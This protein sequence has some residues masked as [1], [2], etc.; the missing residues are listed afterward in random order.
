MKR[1][2]GLRTLIKRW[3]P[4]PSH[5]F[6]LLAVLLL[7]FLGYDYQ[8]S[9]V[10]FTIEFNGVPYP[11]MTH[12]ATVGG[13]L[14]DAGLK[15]EPGDWVRPELTAPLTRG[16]TVEVEPART[17]AIEADGRLIES[18]T[19]ETTPLGVL[20]EAGLA[21]NP[22]DEVLIDARPLA[23]KSSLPLRSTTVPADNPPLP[24]ERPAAQP[25]HLL[26]KRAVALFV[27]NDGIPST[28]YTTATTIGEALLEHDIL[29]YLGDRVTPS[30]GNRVSAGL[31][32]YIQRSK[33]VELV[34]DGHAVRT[35]SRAETVADV[36]AEQYVSLVGKDTVDPP[37][38]TPVR[39]GM[40]IRV[41]RVSRAM[42]VEQDTV[43][44]ET[45]WKPAA[46]LALDQQRVDQQGKEGLT[47]RRIEVLYR[48]GQ[49]VQRE[50]DEEWI[51]AEPQTKIIA[52]GTRITPQTVQTDDG[53]LSYWRKVRMLATSYTAASSGKTRDDPRYGI[54]RSGLPV[55][56]GVVAVDSAVV[57]LGDR[58]YVPGYGIAVVGDTGGGIKGRRIDLGYPEDD[59]VMWY[60]WVDVFVL[61]S[62]PPRDDI[63]WVLPN[64]PREER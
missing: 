28:L 31:K 45:V 17:V 39:D 1:L 13:A 55:E 48:D 63:R 43:A 9:L 30:L 19:H 5:L 47:R 26:V 25:I 46:D 24:W 36:L 41:T 16:M 29:L 38:S 22:F 35:R 51:E 6:L 11:A 61:G 27:D 58:L 52:Y 4:F 12:Q 3:Q 59:P 8:R 18:R 2:A 10:P 7:A 60:R 14:T 32:V 44:F 50:R 40:G 37:E 54:T 57:G 20:T 15:I 53:Q 56:R 21:L 33:A 62:P 49:E 64:W 23:R 42:V 34:A